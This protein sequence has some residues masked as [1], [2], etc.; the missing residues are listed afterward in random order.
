[1]SREGGWQVPEES[2][3]RAGPP[4]GGGKGTGPGPAGE[5]GEGGAGWSGGRDLLLIRPADVRAQG[6]EQDLRLR[7][8]ASRGAEAGPRRLLRR[9]LPRL[10]R[11]PGAPRAGEATPAIPGREA[12]PAEESDLPPPVD[13][14]PLGWFLL[15]VTY[16][17]TAVYSAVPAAG[18]TLFGAGAQGAGRMAAA[19]V[20]IP[21]VLAGVYTGCTA[22]GRGWLYPA[23]FAAW[24]ILLERLALYLFG[25]A[26]QWMVAGFPHGWREALPLDTAL[27]F[28]RATLAPYAT[29][30]YLAA[31]AASLALAVGVFF[32][33]RWLA[34]RVA[35]S[36]F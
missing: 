16:A 10:R 3:R 34:G 24:P 20:V 32:A 2:R 33:T 4:A 9:W 13:P 12:L 5:T 8:Q 25:M 22:G 19:L 30:G 31:G 23:T 18:S 21:Y 1:M 17:L 35:R 11:R 6:L 27:A 36:R 7:E 15:A 28:T 29:V 14:A 26:G